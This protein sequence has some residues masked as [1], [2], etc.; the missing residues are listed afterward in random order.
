M[1]NL[2]KGLVSLIVF[3]SI[4]YVATN[5]YA[6]ITPEEQ[7]LK[8]LKRIELNN[9]EKKA[10]T[11]NL[12]TKDTKKVNKEIEKLKGLKI[13]HLSFPIYKF[14]FAVGEGT[15]YLESNQGKQLSELVTITDEVLGFIEDG[16]NIDGVIVTNSSEPV[17]MTRGYIGADLV[18]LYNETLKHKNKDAEVI[19]FDLDSVTGAGGMFI[20]TDTNGNEIA[21]L[22]EVA[23]N[24]LDLTTKKVYPSEEVLRVIKE[25]IKKIKKDNSSEMQFKGSDETYFTE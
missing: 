21:L 22:G 11:K 18:N 17:T 24:E 10:N 16:D 23:S 1:I 13:S 3:A 15:A 6:S 14:P 9:L 25:N 2:K 19:Y 8:D 5:I 12:S 4:G 20:T 7:A